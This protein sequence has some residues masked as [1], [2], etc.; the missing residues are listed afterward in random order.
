MT[1]NA[2]GSFVRG[3]LSPAQGVIGNWNVGSST[4]KATGIFAGSG[5]PQ[6]PPN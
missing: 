6:I 3:P 4:Y 2:T 5:T 1:G